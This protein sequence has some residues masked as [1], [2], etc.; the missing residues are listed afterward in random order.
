MPSYIFHQGDRAVYVGVY[1]GGVDYT[2]NGSAYYVAVG[3]SAYI[4]NIIKSMEKQLLF[5]VNALSGRSMPFVWLLEP[6]R[7]LI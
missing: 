2:E 7:H 6:R 4:P 1:S 5:A 3:A